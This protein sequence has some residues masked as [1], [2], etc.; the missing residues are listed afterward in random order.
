MFI[1]P[2]I[3]TAIC[4]RN[5]SFFPLSRLSRADT[6]MGR[7]QKDLRRYN[8]ERESERDRGQTEEH[9]E[10]NTTSNSWQMPYDCRWGLGTTVPVVLMPC[11]PD[12]SLYRQPVRA[13]DAS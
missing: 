9:R 11:S 13:A 5:V 6:S 3:C 1:R 8:K 12:C 2:T 10:T 4:K 7:K